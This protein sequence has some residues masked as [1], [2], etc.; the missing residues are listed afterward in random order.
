[1]K[2]VL[3]SLDDAA[4]METEGAKADVIFQSASNSSA[5]VC[6]MADRYQAAY[7]HIDGVNALLK[8]ARTRFE[9]SGKQPIFIQTVSL[10]QMCSHNVSLTT[11]EI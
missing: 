11:F 1:M 3:G 10:F 5:C 4:L 8:G 2:V 6:C 7:D 9:Q